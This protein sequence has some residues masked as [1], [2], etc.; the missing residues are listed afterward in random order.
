MRPF[1]FSAALMLLSLASSVYAGSKIPLSY[2]PRNVRNAIENY[3]P[4]SEITK[5]EIGSDDRWGTTYDCEYNRGRHK[6][7]ITVSERGRLMDLSQDLDPSELP[8]RIAGVA[9]REAR[10]GVIRKASLD[11][12][13]GRLVYKVEAYY[14]ASSA[15]I[16]LK[17]TR[18]GEVIGRD[19]D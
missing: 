13:E 12:D 15:K 2:L 11:E 18:G 1:C 17:I 14:G 5:A 19:F 4:G 16:K 3:V 10:G 9:K 6:G 7:S 8:S